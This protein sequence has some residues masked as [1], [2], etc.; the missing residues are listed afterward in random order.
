MK[1]FTKEKPFWVSGYVDKMEHHVALYGPSSRETPYR[2]GHLGYGTEPPRFD[3]PWAYVV[4][5]ES[6]ASGGNHDLSFIA[7]HSESESWF[8][9]SMMIGRRETTAGTFRPSV[10]VEIN[11]RQ[12][13]PVLGLIPVAAVARLKQAIH[14]VAAKERLSANDL[15]GSADRLTAFVEGL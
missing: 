6:D 3:F 9:W 15:L 10:I 1:C 12:L 8:K 7:Y 5:I 14:N 13:V 4:A 11:R 2:L